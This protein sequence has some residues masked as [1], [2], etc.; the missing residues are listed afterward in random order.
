MPP[1]EAPS[2]PPPRG[3]PRQRAGRARSAA[4]AWIDLAFRSSRVAPATVATGATLKRTT[5]RTCAGP[6]SGF[7]LV[8][9]LVALTLMAVLAGMAWQGLEGISRARGVSH[10]HVAQTL[11]L[12]TVLAQWEQDLQSVFDTPLAP[13]LAFD[14]ATLRLVRRHPEGLQIVAWSLRERRWLRW[15]GPI[16]TQPKALQ[17]SWLASQQLL[18]NEAAQ[19]RMQEGVVRWQVYF[20]RGNA[21]S[22]AQSSADVAAPAPAASAPVAARTQLPTGVRVVLEFEG[23]GQ[24]G[25]LTRDIML[26]PQMQ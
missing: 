3:G 13:A 4:F 7:T 11:R 16:V 2:A 24:A 8:E 19:L 26:A 23:A 22:N 20:Y 1:P 9:V 5:P 25:N 21:W 14:G 18:G 17:A 10:E 15:A 12:N 6:Q